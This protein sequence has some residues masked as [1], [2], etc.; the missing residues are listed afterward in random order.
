MRHESLAFLATR[1]QVPVGRVVQAIDELRLSPA[2]V[3]DEASFWDQEAAAAIAG[4]LAAGDRAGPA[5]DEFEAAAFIREALQ[6]AMLALDGL[7]AVYA[8]D[9]ESTRDQDARLDLQVAQ[10]EVAHKRLLLDR[11]LRCL[12]RHQPADPADLM[13]LA[14]DGESGIGRMLAD[15]VAVAAG[16]VV[17]PTPKE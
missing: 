12:E 2:L 15:R 5:P 6:G 1:L 17:E 16:L 14:V 7:G 11:M 4:H 9:L 8:Q 10:A 13:A 3:L